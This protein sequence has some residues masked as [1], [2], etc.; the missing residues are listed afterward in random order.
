[1]CDFTQRERE[2]ERERERI[3]ILGWWGGW[4]YAIFVC[5]LDVVSDGLV[6]GAKGQ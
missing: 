1:M 5:V 6:K 3:G 2:R 4:I